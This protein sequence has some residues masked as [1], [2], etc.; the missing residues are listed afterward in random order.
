M[1]AM[2]SSVEFYKSAFLPGTPRSTES[3]VSAISLTLQYKLSF[4]IRT[5]KLLKLQFGQQRNSSERSNNY[6]LNQNT[7]I[8]KTKLRRRSGERLELWARY[9]ISLC[10]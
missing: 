5:P 7:S 2:I 4:S 3:A 8:A 9:T 10:G 6:I 1:A